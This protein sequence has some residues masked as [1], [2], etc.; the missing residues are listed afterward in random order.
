VTSPARLLAILGASLAVALLVLFRGPILVWAVSTGAGLA[1]GY[2]IGIGELRVDGRQAVIADLNVRRHGEPVLAVRR[3]HIVY[4]LGEL[5]R[6][7][8]H[9][10]GLISLSVEAPH[11]TI[12]RHKDHSLNIVLPHGGP[13]GPQL[14]SP[15]SFSA[16]VR[17][18]SIEIRD[19][20]NP[21]PAAHLLRIE[22]VA[23]D[24]YVNSE[25]RTRYRLTAGILRAPS[26]PAARSSRLAINGTIDRDRGYAMHRI[27]A[28]DLPVAGFVDYFVDSP[29]ARFLSGDARDLDLRMFSLASSPGSRLHFGGSVSVAG[30]AARVIGIEA[31]VAHLHGRLYLSDNAILAPR[32]DGAIEGTPIAAGG[33][34]YDFAHPQF[35]IGVS[36]SEDLRRLRRFFT[37]L[38]TQ[39]VQGRVAFTALIEGSVGKPLIY[40]RVRLP[41]VR[42]ST[43]PFRRGDGLIAFYADEVTMAPL[44]GRYGPIDVVVRGNMGLSGHIDS[45]FVAR[46]AGP[47]RAI[48]Y[49]DRVAPD[50]ML[51][52]DAVVAGR[53]LPL[54]AR[55]V[56]YGRG[57]QT[58]LSGFVAVDE[59]GRGELGPLT[60]RRADGGEFSGSFALDR[61]TSRSGF[62]AWSR[63]YRFRDPS[64]SA[65]LPGVV[66]P[67]FPAFSGVLDGAFAGG[68]A[69]SDFTLG[70]RVDGH[71]MQFVGIPVT[72]ASV[73]FGGTLHE[74]RLG[75]IDAHG[76]W[77]HIRGAGA[78]TIPGA[79]LLSGDFTGTLQG[80]R[81]F[82]GDIGAS[83]EAS[84]PF[85]VAVEGP[86]IVVQTRGVRLRGARIHGLPLEG[87]DGT[88]AV[89]PSGAI[90]VYG[91]RAR[92]AGSELVATRGSG[93]RVTIA[94]ADLPAQRLGAAGFPLRA[95]TL[96][97]VGSA[98][99]SGGLPSFDGGVTLRGGNLGAHRIDVGG[100]VAFARSKANLS[101]V[102]L[103]FDGQLGMIDGRVEGLGAKPS[104]DLRG[105]VPAAE[106]EPL[107]NALGGRHP[108]LSASFG[109]DLRF[110]G[111]SSDPRVDGLLTVPEGTINGLS[112]ADASAEVS[113]DL[114]A[115][116]LRNGSLRVGSTRASL[117]ASYTRG[118]FALDLRSDAADL[119]DFNDLFDVGEM[120]GG[121]GH[122]ALAYS[123]IGVP[124]T[125]GDIGLNG[126]R[127]R[128]VPLGDLSAHWASRA[129]IA[130]AVLRLGGPKGS[131]DLAGTIALPRGNRGLIES[132][133]YD[134]RARIADLA[135][136]QWLPLAGIAS[137]VVTGKLDVTATARGRGRAPT[138]DL[139][140]DLSDGTIARVPIQRATLIAHATQQSVAI[141]SFQAALPHL[142]LSGDGTIGVAP[143][144]PVALSLSGH[145]DDIG[146]LTG[147]LRPLPFSLAGAADAML[148][149]SG[150]RASP[151]I[152]G[153][154][155][156]ADAR[157]AAL[158]V[159]HVTGSFA[160]HGRSL[161]LQNTDVDLP[162]GRLALAGSLPLTLAPL[163]IGPPN[164]GLSF[165]VESRSLDL[166]DFASLLPKGS[167]I[168]GTLDGRFGVTGTASSPELVGG[169]TLTGGAFGLSGQT[170]LKDITGS[171]SF[172]HQTARLDRLH[173]DAGSG[174]ID[175]SGRIVF[176][177]AGSSLD[178]AFTATARQAMLTVPG[179]FSG[180]VDGE[181][182]LTRT[183]VRPLLGGAVTVSN[184]V[185]P[186]NALFAATAKG[187]SSPLPTNV[188]FD[189]A[190]T[191]GK[192][193]RVRSGAIDI[194]G[195]GTIDLT[196]TLGD[197]RLGGTLDASPGGTLVYFNRV[198]RIVRGT[199]A[200]DPN[201]GIVPIMDAQATTRVPNNDP[202]VARN[203]TGTA[204]ITIDVTG[205]VTGLKIDLTSVPQYSQEQILGLLLGASSVGAVN[206]GGYTGAP[207]TVGGQI[208][209][210]PSVVVGG[211]P[212]G[213]VSQ[214][215]GTISV[216]QQA[217]SLLN[218]QFTQR[219]L[220]PIE[221]TIGSALGLTTLD[222]TVD[223]GGAVGFSARKQLGR[224]N[225]YGVYGQ[226]FTFPYRQTFGIQAQ[227]NPAFS[228]Q[229]TGFVQYGIL[230]FGAYPAN[231]F[232]FSANQ[233]LVAGQ[234]PGGTSGYTFSVQR[235]YP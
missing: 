162:R 4:D 126:V 77:G 41:D 61:P 104:F 157:V 226:T 56:L 39:P 113:G 69:P 130:D 229:L 116:R 108:P 87:F 152:A 197:P 131:L 163:G 183:P 55:G 169:M 50:L 194:G 192:N 124:S 210:A 20:F 17:D 148:R 206:F 1:T 105:R 100:S 143:N 12:I 208:S 44:E 218:A 80:L 110:T 49:L 232:P 164:A 30:I 151:A 18:G 121:R 156:I 112:F 97:L 62:W 11:V 195:S 96:S 76:P 111:T 21:S 221:N 180:Q 58:S 57:P 144:A 175:A 145:S 93:G 53:D 29:A 189:L 38:Q 52:G 227:P 13:R 75:R 16:R 219:L 6:G 8:A 59:R 36:G 128:G 203:P 115:I 167:T 222:L 91:L 60:F 31:P 136:D 200:F 127:Y 138:I 191:A 34:F 158:P 118:G 7:G 3:I 223:Y 188:G 19:P 217:F 14:P 47:G 142:S 90:R 37:F 199:V 193:V 2:A 28:A 92:L 106:L 54:H 153:S 205:P 81:Q 120:L 24:A 215:N 213:L 114:R 201:E 161:I 82:T 107:V 98:G 43:F 140:G 174:A 187:G 154:F 181:V 202:D 225:V 231:P 150:T 71:D 9:R 165:D 141:Q 119:S 173:A 176:P 27:Q 109:A 33:G 147:L 95:G 209:G 139:D 135:V 15:L 235:R 74:L 122:I 117:D 42:W 166:A 10:F 79:F 159:P 133:G 198:F 170:P 32:L 204:D 67:E 177:V 66:L 190:M 171:L 94:A 99:L 23:L 211:L 125:T 35:R 83:G 230:P 155:E 149:V 178:Y 85:A 129:G 84:G 146:A 72:A 102:T 45:E 89:G 196:G 186:F 160:L 137:P 5:L 234:Y 212:P 179:F 26:D 168:A 185:I 184:A 46:L 214:Q 228:L 65:R 224:A 86:R 40:A 123:S 233:S 216:N 88:F 207:Q 22:D 220:S 78:A 73:A 132:T 25:H 134:L 68:G 63:R 64:G 182:S 172:D 70:G 48:P 101:D 103:V 51:H